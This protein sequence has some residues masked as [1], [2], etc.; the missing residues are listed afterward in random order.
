MVDYRLAAARRLMAIGAENPRARSVINDNR[1]VYLLPPLGNL[2]VPGDMPGITFDQ[3][4]RLALVQ[5]PRVALLEVEAGEGFSPVATAWPVL[6]GGDPANPGASRRFLTAGHVLKVVLSGSNIL[7]HADDVQTLPTRN[8]QVVFPG[9]LGATHAVARWICSAN[10]DLAVFEIEDECPALSFDIGA[11]RPE[12]VAVIGYPLVGGVGVFRDQADPYLRRQFL[13]IGNTAEAEGGATIRKTRFQHDATTL[14]GFS[15]API[16]DPGTGH[17]VGLH[18]QGS[19]K[20]LEHSSQAEGFRPVVERDLN[21]GILGSGIMVR[22]D[23]LADILTGGSPAPPPRAGTKAWSGGL[24]PRPSEP[25]EARPLAMLLADTGDLR[26]VDAAGPEGGVVPDRPDK[27]DRFFEP[28]LSPAPP[29]VIPKESP[30]GDQGS[31][32]SCAAFALA[33]AIEIQLARRDGY[34]PPERG[35]TASVRMLDRMARRHDEWLDDTPDGTSLRAVIKGFHHNGVCPESLCA[36]VPR[37]PAFFLTRVIA[38]AARGITLGAYLRVRLSADDMRMAIAEGGAVIVSADVHDGWRSL[39]KGRIPFDLADPP[40][41]R[42]RHAFVVSG[43]DGD[44]FI[45]QNARGREW[46]GYLGLPGH[47]LWKFEDWAQNCRDAWAIRL[48]PPGDKAFALSP[49]TRDQAAAPRRLGLLGHA[50][51]AERFGLVEDGALGL[52]ARGV[53]ETAA[54]LDDDA[55]RKRYPR[56]MLVFH[57]PLM[58]GGLIARLALRLTMRLKARGIYPFHIVYGLDEMLA[59]RLRLSHDIGRAVERYL[60]EGMSRDAAL[61]RQLGP[62]IRTQADHFAQGARDAAAPLLGDALAP[63]VLC[64]MPGRR[65]DAVSV[66]LGGVPAQEVL[67]TFPKPRPPHLAIACPVDIRATR[68]WRLGETMDEA[69]LPGWLG[70]WGDIVAGA[71]GRSIRSPRGAKAANAQALL[72]MPDFVPDLLDRLPGADG[73]R[74]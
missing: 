1:P 69:D 45:I 11:P 3:L 53:A 25:T 58:D 38:K 41:A 64:A 4:D 13:A 37:R 39:D 70:S 55:A 23:W 36:Y 27:R 16:F 9:P 42:G 61:Q 47:A 65:V 44:G 15:G 2:A 40:K 50:L 34:C 43:Y 19:S 46:G 71:F 52:G 17:V 10:L 60:R 28:G 21:D 12:S 31:E 62:V 54:Y 73:A 7:R 33:G 48:A 6:T 26:D 63:L 24:A 51:H 5:A 30:V 74:P 14:P 66:G 49:G 56:L 67:A 68:H 72:S 57:E 35:L 32:G 8:A 59:C 20:G 29:C 22:D 18:V